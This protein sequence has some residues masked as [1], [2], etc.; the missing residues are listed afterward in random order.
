MAR[1]GVHDEN[2]EAPVMVALER[3]ALYEVGV[4]LGEV[5]SVMDEAPEEVPFVI[6]VALGEVL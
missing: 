1:G 4:T 3:G 2:Q 5:P 6:S